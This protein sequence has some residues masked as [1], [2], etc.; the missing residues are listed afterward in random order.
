MICGFS[1]ILSALKPL[2]PSPCALEETCFLIVGMQTTIHVTSQA[3][4]LVDVCATQ[5]CSYELFV[6]HL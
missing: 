6:F 5:L 4:N 3:Y 2:L 1:V